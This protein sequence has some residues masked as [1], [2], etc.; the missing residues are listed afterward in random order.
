M[1]PRVAPAYVSAFI[2]GFLKAFGNP[3]MKSVM[4]KTSFPAYTLKYVNR[5]H[6]TEI[7]MASVPLFRGRHSA[8]ASITAK[9]IPDANW[10]ER[11]RRRVRATTASRGMRL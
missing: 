9:N 8:A 10:T 7:S 4:M 3:P 6:I 2:L 1:I 11:Q 5:S